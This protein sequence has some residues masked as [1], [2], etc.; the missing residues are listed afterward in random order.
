MKAWAW[1]LGG[2]ILWGI[3][4]VG[5]YVIASIAD[6]VARADHPVGRMIAL[7]FSGLCVAVGVALGLVAFRRLKNAREEAARFRRELTVMG[8][9]VAVVAMVWQA[10]P[11]LAGY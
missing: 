5:V 2:L 1:M 7:G 10:L 11:T 8:Y 4:F 6:V 9:G 3:H